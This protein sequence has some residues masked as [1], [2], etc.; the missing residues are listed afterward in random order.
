[1]NPAKKESL[2]IVG[3]WFLAESVSFKEGDGFTNTFFTRDVSE[4]G[5]RIDDFD[6][7]LEGYS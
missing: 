2:T 6:C 5:R 4:I 7:E 3:D 1:M